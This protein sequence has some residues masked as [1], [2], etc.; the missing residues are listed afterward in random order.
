[1]V[2]CGG[3]RGLFPSRLLSGLHVE[4]I[5]V[6]FQDFVLVCRVWPSRALPKPQNSLSLDFLDKDVLKHVTLTLKP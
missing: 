4:A 1:M 6:G 3:F 2:C 5:V